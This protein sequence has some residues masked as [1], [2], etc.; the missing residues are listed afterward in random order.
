MPN[1]LPR[2]TIPRTEVQL[3]RSRLVDQTFRIAVGLPLSDAE[4]DKSYPV[5]YGLDLDRCFAAVRETVNTLSLSEEIPEVLEV[6]VGYPVDD[7]MA[8][9]ASRSASNR[10]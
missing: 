4:S 1:S 5:L 3:L 7:Y 8:S 9:Y 2:L 6:G 10:L